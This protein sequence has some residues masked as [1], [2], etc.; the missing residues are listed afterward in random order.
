MSDKKS[1]NFETS[2][3]ELESIVQALENGNL[4]L[5]E[6]LKTFERGITLTRQCQSSLHEAEQRVNILL[7]EN[8]ETESHPFE[9]TSQE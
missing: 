2:L 3:E 4:T 6:S 8:G 9:Q 1:V 5:E 7:E